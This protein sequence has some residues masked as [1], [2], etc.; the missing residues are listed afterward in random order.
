MHGAE[1]TCLCLK[2]DF[3]DTDGYD[4]YDGDDDSD[5][6]DDGDDDESEEDDDDG[7]DG[8]E[9]DSVRQNYSTQK[10]DPQ[11][12]GVEYPF[13]GSQGDSVCV[14]VLRNHRKKSVDCP[15]DCMTKI[16]PQP[17]HH[18]ISNFP[19]FCHIHH[20]HHSHHNHHNHH[21]HH[22]L[23]FCIVGH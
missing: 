18:G 22:S 14:G 4:D 11:R 10:H 8:G 23:V 2:M 15:A 12:E 3:R 13:G 9:P 17:P 1:A 5:G 7:G 21:S 20:D 19:P 6:D 16:R